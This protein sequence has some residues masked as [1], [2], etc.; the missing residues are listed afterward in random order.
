MK[1][2]KHRRVKTLPVVVIFLV[3]IFAILIYCIIDIKKSLNPSKSVKEMN[4][5]DTMDKYG[6]TLNDSD[7]KYFKEEFKKLKSILEKENID[8]GKYVES[9]AKL[10]LI[11]F[12]TLNSAVNKNDVGGVQFVYQDYRETFLKYAKDA[13]YRYVENNIYKDRKQELPIVTNIEVTD[14]KQNSYRSKNGLIDDNA[15]Y[16]SLK[17]T[18]EKDLGYQTTATL[19]IAH[20]DDKMEIVNM[21]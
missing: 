10:F 13:I 12:F 16:V 4:I 2:K 18:Y 11:D 1:H 5:L 15:Y 19:I 17:I 7:S 6:Y 9:I 3:V 20:N 14:I 21:K 8:E